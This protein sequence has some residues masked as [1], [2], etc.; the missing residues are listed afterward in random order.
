MKTSVHLRHG[1]KTFRL[2]SAE[3]KLSDGSLYVSLVRAGN[4][5]SAMTATLSVGSLSVSSPTMAQKGFRLS[6]HPSGR[7]NFHHISGGPIFMEPLFHITRPEPLID[8][9]VPDVTRLDVASR[10]GPDDAVVDV[11]GGRLT[12]TVVIAPWDIPLSNFPVLWAWS[13]RPL[14]SLWLLESPLPP[15]PLVKNLPEHFHYIPRPH[16][17]FESQPVGQENALVAFHQALHGVKS[18]ILYA[19]NGEG[20]CRLV[21]VVPMRIAPRVELC[22]R[23]LGLRAEI[24]EVTTTEV[25]YRVRDPKNRIVKDAR[26][27]TDIAHLVRDAEL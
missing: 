26:T 1:D 21:F 15:E 19:P 10:I 7:I 23:D 16:G 24:T 2:L 22:L 13:W 9:S 5:D 27:A 20:I 14:F 12:F 6:Y 25:R 3:V 11:L 17:L 18:D 8:I 4:T